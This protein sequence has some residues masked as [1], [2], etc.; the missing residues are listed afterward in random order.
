MLARAE[1]DAS[2]L[3]GKEERAQGGRAEGMKKK[4][5]KYA[6]SR[7]LNLLPRSQFATVGCLARQLAAALQRCGL[8]TPTDF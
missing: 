4:K 1:T 8:E 5:K 3:R 7:I 6:R 2:W